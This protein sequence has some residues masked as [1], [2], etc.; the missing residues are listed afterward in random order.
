MKKNELVQ[1]LVRFAAEYGEYQGR[2]RG[3]ETLAHY[4]AHYFR[5]LDIPA[6]HEYDFWHIDQHLPQLLIGA[7]EN[8]RTSEEGIVVNLRA[9]YEFEVG[10]ELFDLTSVWGSG[11]PMLEV[12]SISSLLVEVTGRQQWLEEKIDRVFN[13][14]RR[15][16]E[17]GVYLFMERV[18]RHGL[19]QLIADTRLR[20]MSG[21]FGQTKLRSYATAGRLMISFVR[22]GEEE[23]QF[24]T[25]ICGEDDLLGLGVGV[26]SVYTDIHTALEMF[27][28][29]TTHWPVQKAAQR[30]IFRSDKK[31][32]LG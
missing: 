8:F 32:K 2:T 22:P 6:E 11:D 27:A 31:V 17:Q 25:I 4:L 24:V 19:G 30:A 3:Q 23:D 13:A 7:M 20:S 18:Y 9:T 26:Q 10:H 21:T 1:A 28:E 5:N 12:H 15:V 14:K 29:V 16:L